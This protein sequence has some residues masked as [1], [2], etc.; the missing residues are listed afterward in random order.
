MPITRLEKVRFCYKAKFYL[1]RTV[2]LSEKYPKREKDA[3]KS[4]AV[5]LY[6]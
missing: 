6:D 1:E 5:C 3:E 2:Y 4:S